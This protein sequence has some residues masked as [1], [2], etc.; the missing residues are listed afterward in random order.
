MSQ[1]VILVALAIL[2][3]VVL[4]FFVY[5]KDKFEKEPLRMLIKAFLFG[6]LL[7]LI[8]I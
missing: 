4:G 3:V 6:C 7:S 2:P 8:H 5:R 1:N